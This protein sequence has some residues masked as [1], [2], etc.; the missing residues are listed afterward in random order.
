MKVLGDILRRDRRS[1]SPALIIPAQDRSY[2]YRRL[3]TYTWKVGNF[4]HQ[5]GVRS[6][7][8]VQIPDKPDPEP[9]LTFFGTAF[10]GGM[11]DW[12]NPD[13]GFKPRVQVLPSRTLDGVETVPET[14]YVGYGNRPDDP[15]I[16]YFERDIWS[17]NPTVPPESVAP[18]DTVL[19]TPKQH[20]SHRDLLR[21]ADAAIDI[22]NIESGCAVAIKGSLQNPGVIAAGVLAPLMVNGSCI[23]GGTSGDI[24]INEADDSHTLQSIIS[25]VNN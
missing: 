16:A 3:C 9:I 1:P 15:S 22:W 23:L 19:A 17:Q 7:I 2:D 4:L 11:I 20:Y 25:T 18:T 6:G 8:S 5:L 13:T 12:R 21:A 14:K 24:V 10:L